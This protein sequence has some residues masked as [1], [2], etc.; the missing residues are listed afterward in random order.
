MS[1]PQYMC[2]MWFTVDMYNVCVFLCMQ[3]THTCT[4][5]AD[6]CVYVQWICVFLCILMCVCVCV[7]LSGRGEGV[8][9]CICVQ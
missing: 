8:S 3:A 9:G 4:L 1:V 6:N 7:W 5:H 2:S